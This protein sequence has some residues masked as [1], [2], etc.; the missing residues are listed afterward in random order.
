MRASSATIVEEVK[1][2]RITSWLTELTTVLVALCEC[3]ENKTVHFGGK[4]RLSLELLRYRLITLG[5]LDEE[6]DSAAAPSRDI[7]P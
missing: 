1:S 7:S 6:D 2:L 3:H 4:A 5:L